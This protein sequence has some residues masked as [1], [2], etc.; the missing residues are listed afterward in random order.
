MFVSRAFTC[1]QPSPSMTFDT[2]EFF[3]GI[4]LV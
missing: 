4:I 1:Y 3:M 2:E